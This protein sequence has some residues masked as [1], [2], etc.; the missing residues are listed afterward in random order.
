MY[1]YPLL[2]ELYLWDSLLR[3]NRM[4]QSIEVVEVWQRLLC[5]EIHGQIVKC[6]NSCFKLC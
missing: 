5:T 4:Y 6:T 1:L 3:N 2:Q